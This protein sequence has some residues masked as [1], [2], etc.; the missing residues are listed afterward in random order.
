MDGLR[1]R[2]FSDIEQF[3]GGEMGHSSIF[4]RF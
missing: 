3:F 2:A 4:F 1:L